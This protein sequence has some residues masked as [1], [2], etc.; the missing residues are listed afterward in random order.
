MDGFEE[1]A[2][3]L[4]CHREQCQLRSNTSWFYLDIN[5]FGFGLFAN[6][7]KCQKADKSIERETE[8]EIQ[9]ETPWS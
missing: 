5:I 6:K 1:R 7:K 2:G 4:R 3:D 8:A 9:K